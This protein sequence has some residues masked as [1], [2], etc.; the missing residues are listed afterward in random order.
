MFRLCAKCAKT[1]HEQ[2]FEDHKLFGRLTESEERLVILVK[3]CFTKTVLGSH[4]PVTLP[5][6]PI[7]PSLYL[8]ESMQSTYVE[9]PLR[10]SWAKLKKFLGGRSDQDFRLM[11]DFPTRE[12]VLSVFQPYLEGRKRITYRLRNGTTVV[13]EKKLQGSEVLLPYNISRD[14]A[15]NI[16]YASNYA[17]GITRN[18][19]KKAEVV[20]V[21]DTLLTI[22]NASQEEFAHHSILL[23]VEYLTHLMSFSNVFD[24]LR[25][26]HN[27][28]NFSSLCLNCRDVLK[29]LGLRK[30]RAYESECVVNTA[31][32]AMFDI[33][34]YFYLARAASLGIVHLNSLGVAAEQA[35]TLQVC[36]GCMEL[37][38]VPG[39]DDCFR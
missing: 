23:M 2:F 14:A 29:Q 10:Q 28:D 33:V 25:L 3:L 9:N 15:Q 36:R 35:S 34:L 7:N 39:D 17:R 4:R 24:R 22:Q 31:C 16:R 20:C 13:T 1:L 27:G 5:T 11:A 12:Q 37:G 19:L 8:L 26:Q 32:L 38:I 18:D 30:S 6:T 21:D